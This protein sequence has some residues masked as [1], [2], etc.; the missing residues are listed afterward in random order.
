MSL[1]IAG[2]SIQPSE[3]VKLTFVFFVASMFYQ[4]TDFKTIFLTTAVA[5]AHVL[6]LVLSKDLGSAL[7]FFVTYLLMLFVATGSWVYLITGKRPGN[8]SRPGSLPAV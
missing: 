4:S 1:T 3:F 7:I 2:V 5:G 6:V 8:R